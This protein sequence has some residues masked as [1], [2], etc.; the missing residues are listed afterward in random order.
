MY[1]ENINHHVLPLC[2]PKQGTGKG[3]LT[4]VKFFVGKIESKAVRKKYYLNE[5]YIMRRKVK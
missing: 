3:N 2:C 1:R 4:I 5:Y